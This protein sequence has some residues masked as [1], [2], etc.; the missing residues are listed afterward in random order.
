M[1][2]CTLYFS[3]LLLM[4]GVP[5]PTRADASPHGRSWGF[6]WYDDRKQPAQIQKKASKKTAKRSPKY[7]P[8]KPDNYSY[9]ELWQLHPD[10]FKAVTEQRLKLAIQYP[11]NEDHIR[12]F[13]EA[14][15]VAKRKSLAFTGSMA[16]V[17]QKYP[18]YD[19]DAAPQN[20]MGKN[21]HQRMRQ[22]KTEAVL[23]AAKDRFGL[24][25]FVSPDCPY[26]EAQKPIIESF[27]GSYGWLVERFDLAT[28]HRLAQKYAI[29]STPAILIV[30]KSDGAALSIS[31][32]VIT[33]TT[34][35]N[36]VVSAVQY[37]SGESRPENFIH[38]L[39]SDPL[40]FNRSTDPG[41]P[42]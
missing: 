37:L 5:S 16:F 30:S 22:E 3:L 4:F 15:D 40:K 42:R 6:F 38:T 33:L 36:R 8:L 34:L 25:V 27:A 1:P 24:I 11:Q 17:S 32:G 21:A 29:N 35:K 18:M 10:H 7:P 31:R 9:K 41:E 12:K 26:C 2:F 20:L 28:H 14:Q 39:S 19:E 13:L 23:T